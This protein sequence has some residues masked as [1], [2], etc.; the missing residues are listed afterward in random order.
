MPRNSESSLE[1]ITV[2]LVY[3]RPTVKDCACCKDRNFGC[4]LYFLYDKVTFIE[5][6]MTATVT[7]LS[8]VPVLTL[9]ACPLCCIKVRQ[10]VAENSDCRRKVRL[11]PCGQGFTIQYVVTFFDKYKLSANLW[12]FNMLKRS[13]I[14]YYDKTYRINTYSSAASSDS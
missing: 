13:K 4:N 2:L 10:F 5:P 11:S 1:T 9:N 14:C 7:Y 6:K 3:Y 12:P 8:K